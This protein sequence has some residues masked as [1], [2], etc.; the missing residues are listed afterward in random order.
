[1]V[2]MAAGSQP[3]LHERFRALTQQLFPASDLPV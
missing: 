3:A 1:V 2:N